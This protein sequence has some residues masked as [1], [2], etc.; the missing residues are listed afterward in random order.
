MPGPSSSTVTVSRRWSRWPVLELG[1]VG[2]HGKLKL[3]PREY[4]AQIVRDASQ[5]GRTLLHCALDTPLHF[6]E[7]VRRP[8]DLTRAARAEIGNIATFA[9]AFRRVGEMQDRA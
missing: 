6:N 2:D 7:G 9:E 4:G 3:E 1:I 8:T 5:H